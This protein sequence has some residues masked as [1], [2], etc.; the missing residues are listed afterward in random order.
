MGFFKS[1]IKNVAGNT[2]GDLLPDSFTDDAVTDSVINKVKDKAVDKTV[3][4]SVD[5]AADALSRNPLEATPP[6]AVP[7]PLATMSVMVAVNGQSY[8]PYEKA[9][10]VEM[11]NNGSLTRDTYVYIQGMQGWLAARHVPEVAALFS[12]EMPIP[13]VPPLPYSNSVPPVPVESAA[14]T[15]IQPS[16]RRV[17]KC[18]HC[19]APVKQL[20]TS[21][22]ECGNEYPIGMG[23]NQGSASERLARKIEEAR[24]KAMSNK[25]KGGSAGLLGTYKSMI[26]GS[27]L[28]DEVN[29][30]QILAIRDFP[31]P[32]NKIDI[33]DLFSS[34]ATKSKSRIYDDNPTK[35]L[36]KTYNNK[37]QEI[38]IKARIVLSDDKP[39][40]DRLEEIAKQYKIK[41]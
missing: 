1:I 11:I 24:E 28:H 8:G 29:D 39:L 30:A 40:L 35:A 10:L 38:L 12:A 27:I 22:P 32:T 26:N 41:A 21:C 36:A 23:A 5:K 2:I 7:A 20:A 25:G 13:P 6:P 14:P 15:A 18:P 19:G 31:I 33:L 9:T 37:A 3:D 16:P 4:K 17:P 34:C